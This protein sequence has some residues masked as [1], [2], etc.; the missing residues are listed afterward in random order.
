[1]QYRKLGQTDIQVS[2]VAFGAWAII[3]GNNWGHQDEKDSLA[4]LRAAYQSGVTLFDSAEGY[5][6]GKSEEL[7][8]RALSDVRD[9]IVI[10]TKVSSSHL[11][12]DDLR[13][14]C[15][16]SL[17]ALRTDRIDLYQLHWP[18]RETPFAE[19]TR[20]TLE[21][22]KQQGKIRAYG[23]SNFGKQDLDVCFS[24]GC[25]ICSNQLAYSLLFRAIEYE[26]QPV[27]VRERLSILCYSSLMQGLLTGKFA[28]ADNVPENRARTRHFSSAR[29]NARHGEEGAEKLTFETIAYLKKIAEELK[30]P[31]ANVS[32]AW[33]LA[34]PGV[35]S[36]IVGA[37]NADQARRNARAA[38]LVLEPAVL[39]RLSAVT[40]KLKNCIGANADMWQAESRIH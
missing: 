22:L 10:A 15:E 20:A 21:E 4:A 16:R 3:G 2:T 12:P 11:A 28:R 23:V 32:I 17:R 31:L 14:A 5:G 30:Q 6:N 18:G 29:P 24:G 40:E 33:L 13:Q 36:A 35:T 1:M 34:Q 38:D 39:Q 26:I 19:D 37:R 7:I 25:K 8:G 27:C 9:R